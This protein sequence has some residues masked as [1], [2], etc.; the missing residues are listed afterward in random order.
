[1]EDDS[2]N[3]KMPWLSNY[4]PD[5]PHH[6]EYPSFTLIEILKNSTLEFPQKI[7]LIQDNRRISYKQL[8]E[9][10]R[11]LAFSFI[12]EGLQIGDR[13]AICL[14]NQIEFVIAFYA[15]LLAGGVVSALNPTYPVR[16]LKFQVDIAQPKFL[17][18]K[19]KM[20]EKIRELNYLFPLK[21]IFLSIDDDQFTFNLL[22]QDGTFGCVKEKNWQKKDLPVLAPD[23]KAVLQFSGGTTGIPKAAIGLHRNIVA[24]VIQFSNWLSPLQRGEEVFLAAIPLFHVYGM[25]IGLNVAFQVGAA[26]VLV[27]DPRDI[28]ALVETIQRER[29]SVF[30]GVPS[31]FNAINQYLVTD[32]NKTSLS[33]LKACISG[34]APLSREIK[35][36]FEKL[37]GAKLVEGYGLSEAPTATHCN[38]IHGENKVGSIGLPLPDVDCKIVDIETS[39]KEVEPGEIGELLLKGPQ[40][41]KGYFNQIPESEAALESG[42]LHTGDIARMDEDGYFYIVGRRKELIKVGGLQVWPNEVEEVIRQIP[43]VVECAVTGIADHNSGEIVKV[44]AVIDSLAEV[45]LSLIQKYCENKLAYYKIPRCFERIDVLP[46]SAVGK[47]LKYKLG[48][49]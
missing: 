16:E 42:W 37:S 26:V 29:V 36:K 47:V 12:N 31:L 46:R 34:S 13:V 38:P 24:N 2:L 4:D 8:Y 27:E 45:N 9:Q 25:V 6:L 28:K 23:K 5:V 43:G 17:V 48:K 21:R 14:P 7:A 32:T 39:S 44:W 30:P 35:N 1:M 33:S 41:M 49:K 10:S 20:T 11:S 15:T 22:N 3:T 40:V 18:S 19:S